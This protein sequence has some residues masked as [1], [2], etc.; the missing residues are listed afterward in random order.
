MEAT[1]EFVD[2]NGDISKLELLPD[3]MVIGIALGLPIEAVNS[4]CRTS[5]K[6][7]KLVCLNDDF[8]RLK[9]TRDFGK[10]KKSVGKT[11][12]DLYET[13]MPKY[14]MAALWDLQTGFSRFMYRYA[15]K[16]FETYVI[17]KKT[18]KNA[19]KDIYADIDSGV[20]KI[21]PLLFAQTYPE[22]MRDMRGDIPISEEQKD[23]IGNIQWGEFLAAYR[24]DRGIDR[25]YE[26]LMSQGFEDDEDTNKEYYDD[27]WKK[28]KRK[29]M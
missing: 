28:L 2:G 8:W 5:S 9:Y 29:F 11:W 27:Y 19:A 20:N 21:N 22:W 10:V 18:S 23:Q 7:N 26:R 6:L 25:I 4:I 17:I 12:R 24:I 16:T 14:A 15:P 3:D 1:V 13:E